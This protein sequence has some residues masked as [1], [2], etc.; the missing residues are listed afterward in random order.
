MRGQELI[1]VLSRCGAKVV[2]L[3]ITLSCRAACEGARGKSCKFSQDKRGLQDLR[4]SW[5]T[6]GFK[7]A[8]Q[9]WSRWD[10]DRAGGAFCELG[11]QHGI[12]LALLTMEIW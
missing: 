7:H 2:S 5:K 11:K 6:V 4:A 1:R 9:P 3:D 8:L 12:H 10:R